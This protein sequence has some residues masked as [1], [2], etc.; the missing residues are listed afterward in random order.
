MTSESG[1]YLFVRVSAGNELQE[2]HGQLEH[3]DNGVAVWLVRVVCTC[4][5]DDWFVRVSAGD[6]LQELHGQLEHPDDGVAVWLVRVVCTCMT[7]ES[8][9]YLYD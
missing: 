3:P 5:T 7:S 1:L 2:L 8:D 4:M 9:L 6:E